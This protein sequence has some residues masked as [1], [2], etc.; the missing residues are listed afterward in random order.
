MNN[1]MNRLAL[2]ATVA[3]AAVGVIDVSAGRAADMAAKAPRLAA[4][5]P[6]N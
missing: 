3:L 6:Y 2:A 1:W 4:A 5:A